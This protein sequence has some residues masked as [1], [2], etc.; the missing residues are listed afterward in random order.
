MKAPSWSFTEVFGW[1]LRGLPGGGYTMIDTCAGDGINGGIGRSGRGRRGQRS[2][3]RQR[4]AGDARPSECARRDHRHA[5]HWLRRGRPPRCRRPGRPPGGACAGP[6]RPPVTGLPSAG[7]G[8]TVDWFEV[9]GSDA[10]RTQQFY[11]QIF[12]WTVDDGGSPATRWRTPEPAGASMAASA[13]AWSP[14]GRRSTRAWPTLTR[15]S[16]ASRASADRAS[17]TP[18]CPPEDRARVALY[19]AADDMKTGA[20]RDPAGNIFG[21]YECNAEPEQ[22]Q[23]APRSGPGHW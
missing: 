13:G 15:P 3:S 11:A 16:A 1:G 22:E 20:F 5:G 4:P 10:A 21:I 6:A 9:M 17:W 23:Q 14:A 19:G 18:R 8:E 12:G 7:P 2:T